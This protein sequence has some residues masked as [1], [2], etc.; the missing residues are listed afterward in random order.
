M[1]AWSERSSSGLS[2]STGSAAGAASSVLLGMVSACDSDAGRG[3]AER[4]IAS[5]PLRNEFC[6]RAL[7]RAWRQVCRP[8]RLATASAARYGTRGDAQKPPRPCL[9]LDCVHTIPIRAS[10]GSPVASAMPGPIPRS[11]QCRDRPRTQADQRLPSPSI[12][13]SLEVVHAVAPV[14]QALQLANAS[15]CFLAAFCKP[16]LLGNRQSAPQPHLPLMKR[17]SMTPTGLNGGP[18]CLWFGELVAFMRDRTLDEGNDLGQTLICEMGPKLRSVKEIMLRLQRKH[19]VP[20]RVQ[21]PWRLGGGSAMASACSSMSQGWLRSVHISRASRWGSSAWP[22]ATRELDFRLAAGAKRRLEPG[23]GR[24]CAAVAPI[25][26]GAFAVDPESSGAASPSGPGPNGFTGGLQ[27][28]GVVRHPCARPQPDGLRISRW[29]WTSTPASPMRSTRAYERDAPGRRAARAWST[30]PP[31]TRAPTGCP[32]AA[33]PAPAHPT[34]PRDPAW[35]TRSSGSSPLGRKRERQ[36]RAGLEQR[37]GGVD[38]PEGGLAAGAV[39]VEAEDRLG[40]HAPQQLASALRQRRAE[41]RHR[42]AEPGFGQGNDVHVAFDH[43]D[44]AALEAPAAGRW[45]R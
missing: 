7:G 29:Y 40:R 37:Q 14:Q 28:A 13:P 23:A 12:T 9:S 21:R 8:T 39:A 44:A 15:Q 2:F 38:G 16:S 26:P 24:P 36:A 42:L 3:C 4:L 35:R 19:R 6:R 45:R 43:D 41:R 34:G 20:Q 11:A 18:I 5:F 10:R 27:S 30:D 22:A 1:T 33:G 17:K 32:P 31:P 25:A